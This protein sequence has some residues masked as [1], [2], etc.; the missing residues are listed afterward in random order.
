MLSPETPSTSPFHAGEQAMQERVGKR[1]MM[2]KYGRM[3][4]RSFMPDQ[5]RKFFNQLPFVVLGSVDGDGWPWASM[6]AGK[7]GFITTPTAQQIDINGAI[8][9]D[10]PLRASLRTGAPIGMLGIELETRRRNRVNARVSQVGEA[11]FSMLVDQSFGNCPQYIQTRDLSMVR[12]PSV[13][14]SSRGSDQF[15]TLDAA[16]HAF[17]SSTD[18]FFVSSFVPA[19][20][21]PETQGVDV[22][23]RG[24]RAGFIKVN[25]NTL[26]IPDYAGNHHFNTLGNFLM[27]PKAGLIFPDFDTGDVTMLTGTVELL[28]ADD[29]EIHAFDG[30]ERGWRFTLHR[31]VRLHDALPFRATF[32]EWSP[33]SLLAGD[34]A[35]ADARMQADAAR[36]QWRPFRVAKI[37]DESSVIRSFYLEPADGMAQASFQAGQFLTVRATP[38][39]AQKPQTRTYTLSSAPGD[40]MYRISVKREEGGAMSTHLHDSVQV[41]DLLE[42][43]A[44]KGAFYLDA[45]ERRPAVLIAAGV[46]ITPIMSMARHVM[47]EG[48]RSRHYRP[49]TIFHAVQKHRP[50]RL[51]QGNASNGTAKRW[52]HSVCV[53]CRETQS[54]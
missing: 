40:D 7:P 46:G 31:G 54:G 4:I 37:R 33:N 3:V 53:V 24:G 23:H 11:G 12:D 25:G 49:L 41:G 16:A 17:I 13:L 51:L 34:W 1:D 22:S 14:H 42:T 18:M 39:D 48:R 47:N 29:P 26:T 44:P 28:S 45:N 5:H 30:A 32:Q 21:N 15:E 20:D 10:D 27:H 50:A 19:T 38:K 36:N 9:V 6:I 52:C 43:K 8:L 35:Q 2:E